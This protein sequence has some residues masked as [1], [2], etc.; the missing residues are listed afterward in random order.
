MRQ[1]VAVILQDKYIENKRQKRFLSWQTRTVCQYI[2]CTVRIEKGKQNPLLEAASKIFL[3]KLE[4]Q[5]LELAQKQAP[6]KENTVGSYERLM[7]NLGKF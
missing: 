1:L 2:A 6:A 5:E 4:S 7:G 3:D